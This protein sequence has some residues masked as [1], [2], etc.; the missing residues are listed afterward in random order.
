MG[1]PNT[2]ALSTVGIGRE[3][4]QV[5]KNQAEAPGLH[6]AVT[7][8]KKAKLPESTGA[9]PKTTIPYTFTSQDTHYR[10]AAHLPTTHPT[11]PLHPQ[12]EPDLLKDPLRWV[13]WHVACYWGHTNNASPHGLPKCSVC[14][15]HYWE[16]SVVMV[17]MWDL[18]VEIR[19]RSAMIY[20]PLLPLPFHMTWG[21]LKLD[22][23][24]QWG[25]G[26]CPLEPYLAM[27]YTKRLQVVAHQSLGLDAN[28]L[29]H[30]V[31]AFLEAMSG[32][33]TLLRDGILHFP[34]SDAH[35]KPLKMWG[36]LKDMFPAFW[37]LFGT[38][39]EDL[40]V[41]IL[42]MHKV[43]TKY[44]VT[45]HLHDLPMRMMSQKGKM[46]ELQLES[47]EGV[48]ICSIKG[49]LEH[50]VIGVSDLI[51]VGPLTYT[52]T[53]SPSLMLQTWS[54]HP[55]AQL[56]HHC[57]YQLPPYHMTLQWILGPHPILCQSC[58]SWFHYQLHQWP[59]RNKPS[60]QYI[61][62]DHLGRGRG[63][64]QRWGSIR[65]LL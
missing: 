61:L 37:D 38:L 21:Y 14:L 18:S 17:A 51:M 59:R 41:G 54:V 9:W 33:F 26:N 24:W 27:A 52:S 28:T 39:D 8:P 31:V 53:I 1:P 44:K 29:A 35:T 10:D 62:S 32:T 45:I 47:F 4:K 6:S 25:G 58:L 36:P 5:H 56:H 42:V 55:H 19:W 30:L 34:E 43:Q 40:L 63:G 20:S 3:G 48:A 15:V 60:R 50:E 65:Y 7:T 13:R 12:G 46:G 16:L 64:F 23:K 49:A 11:E 22:P 57:L 2:T